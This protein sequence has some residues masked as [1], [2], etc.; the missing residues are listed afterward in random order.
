[1]IAV[2]SA[3]QSREAYLDHVAV[4]SGF[5]GVCL[6]QVFDAAAGRGIDAHEA[7][8]VLLAIDP[9]QQPSFYLRFERHPDDVFLDL[10]A[11]ERRAPGREERY[12]LHGDTLRAYNL[13]PKIGG[14]FSR[15]WNA[16]IDAPSE[17]STLRSSQPKRANS[18]SMVLCREA[19]SAQNPF[20]GWLGPVNG[21]LRCFGYCNA[22][23]F[24]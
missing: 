23:E 21:S 4:R 12:N 10:L 1:M 14:G 2:P 24:E 8:A 9:V 11:V 18:A 17:R 20:T 15:V 19:I 6:V 7:S 3:H 5:L 13:A 16:S 22:A